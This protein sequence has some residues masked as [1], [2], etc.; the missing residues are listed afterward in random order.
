M[1]I[2][3]MKLCQKALRFFEI[4]SFKQYAIADGIYRVLFGR[5]FGQRE[6]PETEME[7]Q[8]YLPDC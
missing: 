3:L 1:N 2:L 7:A 6:V 5:R 8:G 4:P